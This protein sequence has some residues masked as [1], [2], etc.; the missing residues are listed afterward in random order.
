MLLTIQTNISPTEDV[1]RPIWER[2]GTPTKMERE[3]LKAQLPQIE[4]PLSPRPQIPLIRSL[5]PNVEIGDLLYK[6]IVEH[7]APAPI[8]GASKR[9]LVDEIHNLNDKVHWVVLSF[10]M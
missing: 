5:S 10:L 6:S 4:R 9:K 7:H 3:K 8:K 1:D 2:P